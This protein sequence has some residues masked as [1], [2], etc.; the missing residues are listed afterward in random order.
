M[1]GYERRTKQKKEAIL[2]AARE[3]FFGNGVKETT[4]SDICRKAKV[5][6]G[7]LYNYFE[8]KEAIL[9]EVIHEHITKTIRSMEDVLDLDLPFAQKIDMLFT[10]RDESDGALSPGFLKSVAWNDPKIEKI[11]QA[12]LSAEAMPFIARFLELG[13]KEGAVDPRITVEAVMAHISAYLSIFTHP[14]FLGTSPAYK[15][16]VYRLFYYGILGK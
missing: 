2:N 11:F 3:L 13:Q 9:Y 12:V 16:G 10:L 5:S 14:D 7:S 4:I 1:N 8:N 15:E 6:Q